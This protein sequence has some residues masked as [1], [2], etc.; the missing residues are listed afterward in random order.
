MAEPSG[1]KKH[2]VLFADDEKSMTVI[3]QSRLKAIGYDVMIAC[4]GAETLELSAREKP[5]I[6]ILDKNMPGM[7]GIE[8]CRKLKAD[9]QTRRIPVVFFTCQMERELEEKCIAAGALGIIYKP[10]VAELCDAIKKVLS[11]QKLDDWEE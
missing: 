2:K 3:I 8:V 6:I 1:A 10:E 5:D 4:N 9:D 11:G 7:D